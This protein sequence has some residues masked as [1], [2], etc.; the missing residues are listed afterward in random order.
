MHIDWWTLAL[1]TVNVLVLIWILGRF[2]F[3]PIADIVAKR[4]AEVKQALADESAA[5]QR[6]ADLRAETEKAR[7][8]VGPVRDQLMAE[9]RQDA[10]T[11]RQRLLAETSQQIAKLRGEAEAAINR[12][13]DAAQAE[14][15]DRAGRLSVEIAKRL[16][17]RFPPQVAASV[18]LD[19]LCTT[20]RTLAAED[21]E[22]LAPFTASSE[23]IDIVTAAALSKEEIEH[24]RGT[25]NAALDTNCVFT[26]HCDPQL[27]AGIELHCRGAIIRNSWRADLNHIA[28]ELSRD[29]R[30]RRS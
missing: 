24:V 15:V 21:K 10:E 11:L 30:P 3:R 25:L 12:E 6:A 8:E 18:F 14:I 4:Q 19:G 26:F 5:R 13:R 7:A 17:E 29:R 9:A 2:F 23:T 1:Q 22:K 16:L 20:I 28:E 27:L